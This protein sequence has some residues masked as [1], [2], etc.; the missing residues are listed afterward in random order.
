MTQPKLKINIFLLLF[1][2]ALFFI[3]IFINSI[4]LNEIDFVNILDQSSFKIDAYYYMHLGS[5]VNNTAQ[6]R[7][8]LETLISLSPNYSSIG[9]VFISSIIDKLNIPYILYPLI[10]FILYAALLIKLYTEKILS[11]EAWLVLVPLISYIFIVSKEAILLTSAMFFLLAYHEPAKIK[12]YFL[13][14]VFYVLI[15]FS[16]PEALL[17]IILSQMLYRVIYKRQ[18]AVLFLFLFLFAVLSI[19]M[20]FH[21]Y[22]NQTAFLFQE[23]IHLKELAQ[24][25]YF[26]INICVKD[27]TFD[28]TVFITR[29]IFYIFLPIKWVLD[30]LFY[31]NNSVYESHVLIIRFVNMFNFILYSLLSIYFLKRRGLLSNLQKKILLFGIS[32]IGIYSTIFF[33]QGSRQMIV[34][35]NI[36]L[37][38]FL[39]RNASPTNKEI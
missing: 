28:I 38:A 18:F 30:F 21:K 17:I 1:L 33:F 6:N 25:N 37:L 13:Y 5:V 20:D 9:V 12:R 24:C 10:F 4:F 7:D 2:F 22:I 15:I 8:Y 34:F 39:V 19:V 32:Y 36:L 31:F 11:K 35:T 16:R 27:D 23:K 14:L 29:L 26:G 3:A